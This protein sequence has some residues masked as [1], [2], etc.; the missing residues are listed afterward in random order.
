MPC[1][2]ED[3]LLEFV[4][5]RLAALELA[6]VHAHLDSCAD[7]RRLCALV[8]YTPASSAPSVGNASVPT[9]S[10]K[11][12][13][14]AHAHGTFGRYF[15]LG[16]LGYGGMGEV[17]LAYDPKLDRNVALKRPR[18]RA[19][20]LPAQ[21]RARLLREAQAMARL[22]HP[23]VLTVH[24]AGELDGEVFIS[25]EYVRGRT[26]RRWLDEPRDW[27]ET[28]AKFRAAGEGLAAAHRAGLI[29]RDFKPDNVLVDED[30]RVRVTDFGL[31]R[32]QAL[33]DEGSE[34]GPGHASPTTAWGDGPE[35]RSTQTG[36]LLGTP[37]YIAPE[38]LQDDLGPISD[39]FSFFVS[40][41]EGLYG[42]RPFEGRSLMDQLQ[43]AQRGELRPARPE[44]GVPKHLRRVLLVGL[45]SN[46]SHRF[47]SMEKAL[48]ALSRVPSHPVRRWAIGAAT[49]LGFASIAAGAIWERGQPERQCR[50]SE[51]FLEGTW[52]EAQ[53]QKV[54]ASFAATGVPQAELTFQSAA[55]TLDRWAQT[56]IKT[57]TEA[58]R[59]TRVFGEQSIEIMDRKMRCLDRRWMDF[60]ALVR[61]F[62]TAGAKLI[63]NAIKA[64]ESLP[65]LYE[66]A[67]SATLGGQDV[68]EDEA[69]RERL[70]ELGRKLAE[71]RAKRL[72][73]DAESGL[74]LAQEVER[75]AASLGLKT[76]RAEALVLV[77]HFHD[78]AGDY[79]AAENISFQA[80]TQAM[81]QGE[82][83]LVAAASIELM[84]VFGNR[85]QRFEEAHRWEQI[86]WASIARAGLF[87][88]EQEAR[89]LSTAGS[90]AG[91]EKAYDVGLSALRKALS[92]RERLYGAEHLRVADTLF[93]LAMVSSDAFLPDEAVEHAKRAL[94][95]YERLLDPEHRYIA[96]SLDV[97][98]V[99]EKR[100]GHLS[101]SLAI[102]ERAAELGA[103]AYARD[104][105]VR[106]DFLY[107]LGESRLDMGDLRGAHDA[108]ESALAIR[109]KS[110]GEDHP[111]VG[112][113]RAALARLAVASGNFQRAIEEGES[114]AR[115]YPSAAAEVL[116]Y[117]GE[118]YRR[119]GKI[120]LA[121]Q[122]LEHALTLL[123]D[124][125]REVRI[126]V[127]ALTSLAECDLSQGLRSKA[128]SRLERAMAIGESVRLASHELALTRF[129]LARALPA[130]ESV[131]ARALANEARSW[132]TTTQRA[133]EAREVERFLGSLP[134]EPK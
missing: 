11:A 29:H 39:Q 32:A 64:V 77:G 103:R 33:P 14:L 6:R 120:N 1:L 75:E 106:A 111:D 56:W 121:R 85:L 108:L 134:M 130:A 35:T 98:G 105:P 70:D 23:N 19:A 53:R 15:I 52:D 127:P 113:A 3:V 40:L 86:A 62:S 67:S 28:L 16:T 65:D 21:A 92:I 118:A 58:C 97:L 49:A 42:E 123:P 131:R 119:I 114:V 44:R 110:L 26:L 78:G 93:N 84:S 69:K 48:A 12:V 124:K 46:P 24:D 76:L 36:A 55:R 95:I 117:V 31:A 10:T 116:L 5:G 50:G 61:Q 7:C 107:N 100:A 45:A 47:A 74:R 99:L 96:D 132:L 51:R 37:G 82:D 18:L 94:A 87:G 57:R 79:S 13:E 129:A 54:R 41:Y 122:R 125:Q 72:V 80:V 115:T 17:V 43:A 59:A 128:L 83:A 109:R 8:S 88:Q 101:E 133:A 91:Y 2:D 71:A 27:R 9:E 68:P 4:Q 126:E 89:L 112:N 102:T 90:I 34:P 73:E 104:H 60:D 30:G 38:A 22:A 63:P 20:S 81:A 66:C 25:M